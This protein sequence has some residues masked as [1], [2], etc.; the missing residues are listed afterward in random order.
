MAFVLSVVFGAIFE[1][2]RLIGGRVLLNVILGRY[3]HPTREDRVLS[4]IEEHG[5]GLRLTPMGRTRYQALPNS[6]AV[7]QSETPAQN[8]ATRRASR[9]ILRTSALAAA[10]AAAA[11]LWSL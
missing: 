1:L 5:G 2:T 11:T 10:T 8:S 4:L 9:S 3:R 6:A 7:H